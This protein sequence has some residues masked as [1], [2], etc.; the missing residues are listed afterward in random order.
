MSSQRKRSTIDGVLDEISPKTAIL[1][2]INMIKKQNLAVCLCKVRVFCLY[3]LQKNQM[4]VTYTSTNRRERPVHEM[5]GHGQPFD[6]DTFSAFSNKQMLQNSHMLCLSHY[7][8]KF[9]SFVAFKKA[10]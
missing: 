7:P 2:Q 5:R 4:A 6:A 8:M 9:L 3:P 10:V 1:T